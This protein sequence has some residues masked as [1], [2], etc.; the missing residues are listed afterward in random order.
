MDHVQAGTLR[1]A[2]PFYDFIVQEAAP[3]TAGRHA[4][5]V[6]YM[7]ATNS[8]AAEKRTLVALLKDGS[9]QGWPVRNSS[10]AFPAP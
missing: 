10:S 3:L 6:R 7:L 8:S 1:I 4:D 5:V 9:R 2:K